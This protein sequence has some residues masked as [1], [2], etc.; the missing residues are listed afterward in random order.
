MP[1]KRK[2]RKKKRFP[3]CQ[4]EISVSILRWWWGG[5]GEGGGG[6]VDVVEAVMVGWGEGSK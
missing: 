6:G 4:L 3:V 5:G 1:K 2:E